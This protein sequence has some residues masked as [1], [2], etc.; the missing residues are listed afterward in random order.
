[1]Y[2]SRTEKVATTGESGGL[3]REPEAGKPR[4]GLSQEWSLRKSHCLQEQEEAGGACQVG[5]EP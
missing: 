3:P 2:L 1:M 5:P 4:W